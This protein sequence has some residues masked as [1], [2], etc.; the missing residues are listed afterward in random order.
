MTQVPQM[1]PF[2]VEDNK[3]YRQE[4]TS[5][6]SHN[7]KWSSQDLHPGSRVLHFTALWTRIWQ[8]RHSTDV[9]CQRRAWEK[10]K[11]IK[12]RDMRK[13]ARGQKALR[14]GYWQKEENKKSKV[15]RTP[16]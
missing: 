2:T 16:T 10:S 1:S 5:P 12:S 9:E 15:G 13:E 11:G 14:E 7:W 6:K 8:N 3:V 4:L